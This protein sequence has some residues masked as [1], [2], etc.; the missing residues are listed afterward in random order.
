ME[1]LAG[2]KHEPMITYY[3]RFEALPLY[4]G[5]ISGLR[6][7]YADALP[8]VRDGLYFVHRLTQ[9]AP[10]QTPLALTW[11]DNACSRFAVDTNASGAPLA[12]QNVIL[13]FDGTQYLYTSDDPPIALGCLPSKFVESMGPKLRAG[14]LLR[15]ALGPGG[16]A[17]CNGQ[18][19][20]AD[21][22]FLGAA[23][24]RRGRADTLSKILFQR[25]MRTQ[26]IT[27]A[28]L[29]EAA[30]ASEREETGDGGSR[31]AGASSIGTVREQ[32]PPRFNMSEDEAMRD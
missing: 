1:N 24:Q 21:L 16:V 28:E 19:T 15:F 17:F 2:D 23:N 30:G 10:G 25:L 27:I 6:S 22:R 18:P 13:R 29:V 4:P 5:T 14:R 32:Q 31:D 12:E 8:F 7:A 3:R 11:K 26:P 9:Y 20:G